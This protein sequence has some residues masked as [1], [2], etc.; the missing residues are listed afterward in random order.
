MVRIWRRFQDAPWWWRAPAKGAI[1]AA[2]VFLVCFPYPNLFIRN[3]QHWRN[4]NALIAPEAEGLQPWL[5]EL[6]P[7]LEGKP[8]GAEALKVVEGFVYEKVPYA[9]DWDTW[10]VAD[11]LPTVPETLQA[12]AEDCD[13]RALISASLLRNLGYKADLVTDGM[14][15]WVKTDHGE[16]MSPGRLPKLIEAKDGQVKIRWSNLLNIP[17]SSAFAVSVF[18]LGRELII[19]LVFWS[20]AVRTGMRPIITGACLTMLV[21]GLLLLRATGADA[22][23]PSG[24]DIAGQWTS[25]AI[26]LTGSV[27]LHIL[28]RR[29]RRSR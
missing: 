5:D 18:P 13:G 15:V 11:Y 27:I 29:A 20:L 2:T 12:G 24:L 6:R 14:H 28:H 4:P 26:L 23:H 8:A 22:W 3:V 21:G 7:K 10:G 16:T 17:K 1:L 19:L 9:W 25:L